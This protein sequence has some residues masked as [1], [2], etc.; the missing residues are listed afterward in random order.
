MSDKILE[1]IQSKFPKYKQ[2]MVALM[3][4]QL[5]EKGVDILYDVLGII[6]HFHKCEKLTLNYNEKTSKYEIIIKDKIDKKFKK[7]ID[8]IFEKYPEDT[9]KY[10]FLVDGE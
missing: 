8:E 6:K 5:T 4:N 10:I 3:C 1:K 7:L 2:K 9:G